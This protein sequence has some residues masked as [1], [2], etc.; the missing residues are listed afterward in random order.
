MKSDRLRHNFADKSGAG[1]PVPLNKLFLFSSAQSALKGFWH[2][3]SNKLEQV[4]DLYNSSAFSVGFLTQDKI[5]QQSNR[6]NSGGGSGLMPA[7][8]KRDHT[9]AAMNYAQLRYS[10]MATTLLSAP[11][12]TQIK[13]ATMLSVL[14]KEEAALAVEKASLLEEL[15]V[16]ETAIKEKEAVESE[17]IGQIEQSE[18]ELDVADKIVI[19]AQLHYEEAVIEV[20]QAEDKLN[21]LQTQY[22]TE[23]SVC[24]TAHEKMLHDDS[25]R[26]VRWDTKKKLFYRVQEDGTVHIYN[27][28]RQAEYTNLIDVNITLENFKDHLEGDKYMPGNVLDI[29]RDQKNA[30]EEKLNQ[31]NACYN[32]A[33]EIRRQ[34]ETSLEEAKSVYDTV[35]T[36]LNEQQRALINIRSDLKRLV[37]R[38]SEFKEDIELVQGALDN[39]TNMRA[40]LKSDETINGIK[41][42]SIT[43]EDIESKLKETPRLYQ[44]Y[45]KT[46]AKQIALR[47]QGEA[48]HT[49]SN[50]FDASGNRDRFSV[51]AYAVQAPKFPQ[52]EEN[53][54]FKLQKT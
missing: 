6:A 28:A 45:Q 41:D 19:K 21:I 7:A 42:G 1:F 33:C 34:A 40:F 54:I 53:A 38:H 15:F 51:P 23:D 17:I 9:I 49:L 25:D 11:L 5:L 14:A 2:S 10:L 32:G 30:I 20:K 31:A 22:N 13:H 12:V 4:A 18:T 44:E 39:I 47:I 8:V 50:E 29:L 48:P 46:V 35:R 52:N 3:V 36:L 43:A 37:N 26:H 27:E 16:T 24:D